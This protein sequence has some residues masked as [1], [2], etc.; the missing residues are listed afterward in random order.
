MKRHGIDGTWNRGLV[1]VLGATVMLGFGPFIQAGEKRPEAA[2]QRLET[3]QAKGARASLT[4]FPVAIWVTNKAEKGVEDLGED[5]GRVLGLLL[6]KAGM[7]NLETTDSVFMLPADV[8]F[9]EAA[10]RFGGF[11]R[12]N[13]IKTDYALY[14]ELVGRTGNPPQFDEIRAVIVDKA[15]DRV[16]V[17]R[18][19]PDDPDFRRLKPDCPM[20]CC[21]FLSERV[22]TQLG[23]PDSAR[24]DSGKGNFARMLAENSPGPDQAEGAAIEQRQAVMR[25]AG[26][27]AKLAVFPVRLS[28]DKVSK[29][30][31]AYLANLLNKRKL[32]E[33]K[34]MD[35]PLRVEIQRSHNEQKL[36]WD[37]ARAFRDHVRH[38]PPEADYAL[39]ADYMI[40]PQGGRVG[41]VHFV[42]CDRAGEWVIVDFQNSHWD[43]FQSIDPKTREDCGRLVAKRLKGYLR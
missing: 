30:S 18:Q 9:D 22:R 21:Y 28:D 27:T 37:L 33:A 15:G 42:V 35:S 24:D 20:T 32:G 6:E 23:I 26:R 25:K 2:Q 38:N 17:D 13:P 34:A 7:Q 31:A 43:D 11:V 3:M 29:E 16:W 40:G 1:V 14:A 36:L 41:A 4:I 8:G 19:T 10:K 5:V 12:G 39:L